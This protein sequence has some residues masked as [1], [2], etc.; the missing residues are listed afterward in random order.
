M[1][2]LISFAILAAGFFLSVLPAQ[3]AINDFTGAWVN[4]D[5]GTRG[6]TKIIVTRV[7]N[8][9]TVQAFGSC[10]P[11]DC[12]WGTV[13][14]EVYGP[15]VGSNAYGNAIAISAVFTKGFAETI[16]VLTKKGALVE[17]QF[18]T[19]FTDNSGRAN[20]ASTE[21]FKKQ[22]LV[23]APVPGLTLKPDE[24]CVSFNNATVEAKTVG[25]RWKI[26]DGSHWIADFG[27]NE[28]EAKDALARIK[29]YG[30]TQQCFVGRPD[31]SFTYWL[32]DGASVAGPAGG[33]EDCL[34]FSNADIEVKKVSGSWKIV[35]GSH[36]MFDFGAKEAEAK[37]AF[38]IIKYHGFAHTCYVGRPDPSMVY[39]L[40]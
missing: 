13:N 7:T 8:G 27:S 18:L 15:G 14:A 3:A 26:V 39:L 31:P 5:A 20:Y 11:S 1:R 37:K 9:T 16:V 12:D 17:A 23:V 28:A 38:A 10:S 30:F 4:Q 22:M 19:R 36:W 24:D 40:K 6:V 32:K 35:D 2:S 25:G 29:T 34:N 21:T 33:G